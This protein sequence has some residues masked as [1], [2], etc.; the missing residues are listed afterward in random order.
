MAPSINTLSGYSGIIILNLQTFELK[1]GAFPLIHDRL[2]V[3]VLDSSSDVVGPRRHGPVGV[4]V[5]V[6]EQAET[7]EER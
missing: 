1:R 7:I 6:G 5:L 4:L 2:M 3:D